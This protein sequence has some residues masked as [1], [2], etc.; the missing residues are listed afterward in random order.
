MYSSSSMKMYKNSQVVQT[1]S[2]YL[3]ASTPDVVINESSRG[4]SVG[5]TRQVDC[6][7]TNINTMFYKNIC[8]VTNFSFLTWANVMLTLNISTLT[9][10][11][12]G[13]KK[14]KWNLSL[15]L[16]YGYHLVHSGKEFL[17]KRKINDRSLWIS[18]V[19]TMYLGTEKK[20]TKI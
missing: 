16:L 17:K 6:S 12:D 15:K 3:L 7:I 20:I 18:F 19:D 9:W 1:V 10:H 8:T 13:M 5:R 11:L 4:I 2:K 14:V